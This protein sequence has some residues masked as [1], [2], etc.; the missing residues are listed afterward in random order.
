MQVSVD[1]VC[2]GIRKHLL[3]ITAAALD[4]GSPG[5]TRSANTR[6]P[7]AHK[8]A[9]QGLLPVF[10]STCSMRSWHLDRL[11]NL[12]VP[13]WPCSGDVVIRFFLWMRLTLKK[14]C[15]SFLLTQWCVF[16]HEVGL[17]SAGLCSERNQE[18]HCCVDLQS[19]GA[20]ICSAGLKLEARRLLM[21]SLIIQSVGG[22]G[23]N[24]HT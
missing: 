8:Q 17:S 23:N 6:V 22:A 14:A 11:C 1:S 19:C 12:L 7:K 20:G 21:R 15:P 18:H 13:L 16:T 4:S 3:F 9:P 2:K 5:P 10:G 24:A